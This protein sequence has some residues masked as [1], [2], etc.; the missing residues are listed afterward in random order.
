MLGVNGGAD[1]TPSFEECLRE[2]E[3]SARYRMPCYHMMRAATRAGDLLPIHLFHPRY[4]KRGGREYLTQLWK[5]TPKL[6]DPG[7]T[8]PPAATAA[9]PLHTRG[10]ALL[11]NALVA[12]KEYHVSLRG[13]MAERFAK[14]VSHG[15]TVAKE[16]MAEAEFRQQALPRQLSEALLTTT[17]RRPPKRKETA[18]TGFL[19]AE[20][21]ERV[22]VRQQRQDIRKVAAARNEAESRASEEVV[23]TQTTQEV[24]VLDTRKKPLRLEPSEPSDR[25][26][27]SGDDEVESSNESKSDDDAQQPPPSSRRNRR[28]PKPSG[29]ILSQQRRQ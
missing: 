23:P 25:S 12:A 4:L 8:Q 21:E 20:R 10:S 3:L 6:P 5:M 1:P 22:A 29:G 18:V 11:D 28:A 26:E 13:E 15:I 16:K 2:C 24:I 9:D 7:M 17:W 14:L 27:Q 19:L